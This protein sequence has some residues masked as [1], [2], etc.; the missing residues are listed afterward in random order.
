LNNHSAPA[1]AKNNSGCQPDDATETRDIYAVPEGS[2]PDDF[3]PILDLQG[4]SAMSLGCCFGTDWPSLL[5]FLATMAAVIGLWIAAFHKGQV[6]IAIYGMSWAGHICGKGVAAS[7]PY[8]AWINPTVTASLFQTAVCMPSCPIINSTAHLTTNDTATIATISTAIS[9]MSAGTAKKIN[10]EAAVDLVETRVDQLK[11]EVKYMAA[12]LG[13]TSSELDRST[14]FCLC[15]PGAYPAFLQHNSNGVD[16]ASLCGTSQAAARGYIE[17]PYDDSLSHYV[18]V[19]LIY[20]MS[21]SC[22]AD[23][24]KLLSWIVWGVLLALLVILAGLTA[25]TIREFKYYKGRFETIPALVT[26]SEDEYSMYL[27]GAS[28][29]V[30]GI[31]L[32]SHFIFLLPCVCGDNINKAISIIAAASEVFDH[33]WG[34]L[35]YPIFH[36]IA[37]LVAVVCWLIGLVFIG[38]AGEVVVQSNGVHSL[39]YNENFQNAVIFYVLSIVWIIEFMS[40]V[41]FMVVTGAILIA[42]FDPSRVDGSGT[43]RGGKRA[44]IWDSLYL[45]IGNHLGL[46]LFGYREPPGNRRDWL[47]LHHSGCVGPS[48]ADLFD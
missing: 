2:D 26:Q 12:Q 20:V 34:V 19:I 16:V 40:A 35:F 28:M 27:Y 37:L 14:L 23:S 18:G 21:C 43:E 41:G 7:A 4:R 47:L 32:V 3:H 13:D 9:E 29:C 11:S 48:R 46:A 5:V 15:N 22:Y 38:T 10:A 31:L 39:E 6:D 44:P 24:C 33:A 17:L 1:T 36:N 25:F 42:F 8:Q 30:S 45:V